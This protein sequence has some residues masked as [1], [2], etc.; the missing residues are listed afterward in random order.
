MGVYIL[1]NIPR[2]MVITQTIGSSQCGAIKCSS[3]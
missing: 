2:G 3:V 1:F